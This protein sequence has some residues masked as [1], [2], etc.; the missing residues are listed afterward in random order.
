[1]YHHK[2]IKHTQRSSISKLNFYILV[3]STQD[4][5]LCRMGIGILS[6][7]FVGEAMYA[8]ILQ[9]I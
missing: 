7:A 1:M 4:A 3:L 9:T 2:N 5:T 8:K 6:L